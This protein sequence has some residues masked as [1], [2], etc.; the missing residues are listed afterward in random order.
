MNIGKVAHSPPAK[1]TDFP[2]V[3]KACPKLPADQECYTPVEV[4]PKERQ[5]ISTRLYLCYQ[6]ESE[7]L[8]DYEEEESVRPSSSPSHFGNQG[9]HNRELTAAF[10]QMHVDAENSFAHSGH[11]TARQESQ[12]DGDDKPFGLG[13]NQPDTQRGQTLPGFCANQ[14]PE[15]VLYQETDVSKMLCSWPDKDSPKLGGG[16]GVSAAKWLRTM[17]VLLADRQ[18]HPGVWHITAGPRLTL[19]TFAT[20]PRKKM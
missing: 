4:N 10:K 3:T 7:D 6:V 12:E 20:L 16:V 14:A 5:W 1:K 15:L 2:P 17:S 8:I 13:Q 19:Q 11:S 18:A 9:K